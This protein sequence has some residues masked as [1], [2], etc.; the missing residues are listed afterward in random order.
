MH[1]SD[2]RMKRRQTKHI[3]VGYQMMPESLWNS[4]AH[5]FSTIISCFD[6]NLRDLKVLERASKFL[7]ICM[8]ANRESIIIPRPRAHQL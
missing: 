4:Y 1:L 3:K 6:E 5:S 2:E 7:K 8:D